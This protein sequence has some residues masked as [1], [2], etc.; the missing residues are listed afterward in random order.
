MGAALET[1]LLNVLLGRST[2]TFTLYPAQT[3]VPAAGAVLTCGNATW[4]SYANIIA[5]G[6]ISVE[7]WLTQ[8]Q[9]DTATGNSYDVQIYNATLTATLW[10]A[11]VNVTAATMNLGPITFPF[12]IRCNAGNQIQG[13]AGGTN[14]KVIGVSLLVATGI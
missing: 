13:R 9:W 5:S 4:G 2:P 8:L 7:F 12:P 6:A 11:K 14:T 3:G 1:R 10:Q